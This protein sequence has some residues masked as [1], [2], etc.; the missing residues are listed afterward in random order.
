MKAF[1]SRSAV[2]E[3]ISTHSLGFST[4]D[5]TLKEFVLWLCEQVNDPKGKEMAP[6]IMLYLKGEENAESGRDLSQTTLPKLS[7]KIT[8]PKTTSLNK[9]TSITESKFC[10]ECGSKLNL[11]SKFCI[12]CGTKQAEV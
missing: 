9:P 2:E 5:L 11:K 10:I 4:P 8:E 3:Y 6:R 12:R 1:N 7:S